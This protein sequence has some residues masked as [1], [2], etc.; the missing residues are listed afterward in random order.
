MKCRVYAVPSYHSTDEKN[1]MT[2]CDLFIDTGH[3][4][5]K[6]I[7]PNCYADTIADWLEDFLKD[8]P[9]Q[10]I[11]VNGAGDCHKYGIYVYG[12][13]KK[14]LLISCQFYN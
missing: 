9:E 6:S 14:T 1:D 11:Y 10:P 5:T 7:V 12:K 8:I 3:Y 13:D 4:Y 2:W